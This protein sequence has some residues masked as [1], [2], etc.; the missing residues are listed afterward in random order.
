M[1][2]PC[3]NEIQFSVPVIFRDAAIM[4]KVYAWK[5]RALRIIAKCKRSLTKMGVH[6]A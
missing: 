5:S 3:L 6:L 2:L 4:N 1:S